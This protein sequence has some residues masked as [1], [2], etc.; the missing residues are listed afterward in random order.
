MGIKSLIWVSRPIGVMCHSSA[1]PVVIKLLRQE[2]RLKILISLS[3]FL[4]HSDYKRGRPASGYKQRMLYIWKD[5]LNWVNK[6]LQS[7]K[8]Q[9]YK[10]LW[11]DQV[12]CLS[13][14]KKNKN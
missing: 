8:N 12:S 1:G 9:E 11:E 14:K 4:S 13:I 6:I 5:G 10:I 7:T 3:Y 2:S